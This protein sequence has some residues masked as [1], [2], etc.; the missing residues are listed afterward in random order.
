MMRIAW[1][2]ILVMLVLGD[3]SPVAAWDGPGEPLP[4]EATEKLRL[5]AIEGL[6]AKDGK[7]LRGRVESEFDQIKLCFRGYYG[8]R[9]LERWFWAVLTTDDV[10]RISAVS[11]ANPTKSRPVARPAPLARCV[12]TILEKSS[13]ERLPRKKR[14]ILAFRYLPPKNA[15]ESFSLGG[16]VASAGRSRERTRATLRTLRTSL[17]SCLRKHIRRDF[18]GGKLVLIFSVDAH[19]KA[20]YTRLNVQRRLTIENRSALVSC[21]SAVIVGVAWG[22]GPVQS[23]IAAPMGYRSGLRPLTK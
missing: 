14:I 16:A 18:Q 2:A 1:T 8:N 15:E 3:A 12:A 9:P 10:G 19:G 22:P 6:T 7:A 4:I 13:R 5:V 11:Y 20:T 23:V 17:L 21:L